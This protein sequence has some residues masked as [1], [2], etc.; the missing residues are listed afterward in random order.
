MP[1][2]VMQMI[3]ADLKIGAQCD[4]ALFFACRLMPKF[5]FQSSDQR[6]VTSVKERQFLRQYHRRHMFCRW[7]DFITS[8][9]LKIREI[10][11]RQERHKVSRALRLGSERQKRRFSLSKGDYTFPLWKI[12]AVFQPLHNSVV[13]FQ[14]KIPHNIPF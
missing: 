6:L 7:L 14:G 1:R 11:W 4:T 2:I 9:L 10:R 3:S 8:Q 13:D 5:C 12:R